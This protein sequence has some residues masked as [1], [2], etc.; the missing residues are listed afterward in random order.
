MK[1][2]VLVGHRGTCI[3][4]ENTLKA[5]KK[6]IDIGVDMIELDVRLSKDKI[7]VVIHDD[8]VNRTTNGRGKVNEMTLK[9]LK[10]LDAGEG[11]QI[12]TLQEVID[13]AK[14]KTKLLIELKTYATIK[15]VVKLIKDNNMA[16]SVM[17]ASFGHVI[18]KM[19]KEQ[20]PG[21]KTGILMVALP[22]D[23]LRTVR[24][25]KADCLISFYETML[26]GS[27]LY[28]KFLKQAEKQKIQVF[29]CEVNET[30]SISANELKTLARL[31][32]HGF[33]LNKP[34]M[35]MRQFEAKKRLFGLW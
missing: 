7:P 35:A 33:V 4:P 14:D 11:Q 25:A 1:K 23:P 22:V 16:D 21:I 31:G 30:D 13:L 8:D 20:I 28:K 12:P 27:I 17:I 10:K 3:E 34:D 2:P 6:A 26:A 29:A 18:S 9:E 19:F 24:D 32:V 5:F 15:P